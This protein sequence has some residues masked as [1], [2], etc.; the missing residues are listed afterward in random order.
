VTGV[1]GVTS[2]DALDVLPVP[3]SVEVIC[4]ELFLVPAVVPVTFAT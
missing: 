2:G 1:A 4:T 3:P